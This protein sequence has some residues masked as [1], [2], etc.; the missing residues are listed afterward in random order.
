[1]LKRC[2]GGHLHN[3]ALAT[4]LVNM[5][6]GGMM[7][8]FLGFSRNPISAIPYPYIHKCMSSDLF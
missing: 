8:K 7:C 2:I 1:M 3:N 5:G 4:F 6:E